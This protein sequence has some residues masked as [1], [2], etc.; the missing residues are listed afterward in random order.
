MGVV[1]TLQPFNKKRSVLAEIPSNL[2]EVPEK[3]KCVTNNKKVKKAL[4]KKIEKSGYTFDLMEIRM[5]LKCVLLM[6]LIFI[7]IFV[8]WRLKPK[9][10]PCQMISKK[11]RRM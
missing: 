1:D 9:D 5:T 8:T 3:L 7:N 4:S 11:F 10:D 2:V 6:L